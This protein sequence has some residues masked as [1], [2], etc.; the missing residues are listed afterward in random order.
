MLGHVVYDGLW[1]VVQMGLVS[2]VPN[3]YL[4]KKKWTLSVKVGHHIS[5][6]S[7]FLCSHVPPCYFFC[8]YNF[9]PNSKELTDIFLSLYLIIVN[10]GQIED[11][12]V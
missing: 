8:P 3:H 10:V 12:F 1:P 2:S 9:D 7:V 4:L 5:F 11:E 6:L